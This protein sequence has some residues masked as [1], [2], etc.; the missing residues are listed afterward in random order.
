MLK[1]HNFLSPTEWWLNIHRSKKCVHFGEIFSKLLLDP[2]FTVYSV[3]CSIGYVTYDKFICICKKS[4]TT[5]KQCSVLRLSVHQLNCFYFDMCSMQRA[6]PNVESCMFVSDDWILMKLI[7]LKIESSGKNAMRMHF[8]LGYIVSMVF[9]VEDMFCIQ[10]WYIKFNAAYDARH[11]IVRSPCT[12]TVHCVR[13]QSNE[14]DFDSL[15]IVSSRYHVPI[16]R[17]SFNRKDS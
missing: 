1:R 10:N 12:F 4:F 7:E 9:D 5:N 8:S 15:H 16:S 2:Q 6:V 14:L 13:F 3:Q 17:V 11:T